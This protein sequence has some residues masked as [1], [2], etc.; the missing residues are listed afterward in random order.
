ML[1][2]SLESTKEIFRLQEKII[3]K[4]LK[5]FKL[6]NRTIILPLIILVK[7]PSSNLY[8]QNIMLIFKQYHCLELKI[9]MKQERHL[10]KML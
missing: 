3:G 6:N 2:L 7:L 8:S 9:L 1:K 4:N 5:K 10:K